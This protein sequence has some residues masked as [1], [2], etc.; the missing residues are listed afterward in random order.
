MSIN[1]GLLGLGNIGT[2][3]AEYL[4]DYGNREG[5]CLRAVAD[6]SPARL[7][8][9]ALPNVDIADDAYEIIRSPQLQIVVELIGGEHPAREYVMEAIEHGKAVVTANKFTISR[10]GRE[11]FEAARKQGVDVG[12]EASV[13]GGIPIIQS[14]REDLAA[15]TISLIT[16]IVNGTT[17]Y[18]LTRMS[19]GMEYGDA[20][21]VAQEKG[22]AER[23]PYLDVSGQD[24]R[25]KLA[26][27][28]SVA[29]NTWI[30][31]DSISCEGTA[32]ITPKD[33]DFAAEF[34]YAIKLLATAR[35]RGGRAELR[36][37]PTLVSVYHPLAKVVDEFNAI[38]LE[39]NLCGPQMY[40]GRGAGRP[41]TTSAVIADIMRIARDIARGV[42]DNLPS[43]DEE[44][45]LV[46]D[47]VSG[48]YFRLDLKHVAGSLA[49]V[50]EVLAKHGI[51]IK[52]SVQRN[53]F[54]REVDGDTVIPDIIT[55]EPVE[56][57]RV[58]RALEELEK[59]DR[60][61]GKPF[62]LRI[63][64]LSDTSVGRSGQS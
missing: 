27:L 1:V 2:G 5:L 46:E 13:G 59:C 7:K 57:S 43:L 6:V 50:A 42:H 39:G 52:D 58:R 40:L 63:E 38:Y 41:A 3:V 11:I 9:T 18:I 20:L 17:N 15:N 36:V 55:V 62:Y 12:F 26:I 34:G 10:Y 51:S 23:D 8:N 48:G 45:E 33:M 32:E 60:V 4:R 16:G 24:A 28:A 61:F 19:E 35:K 54:R 64:D 44:H 37:S 31:P 53:R 22:F 56:D 47:P 30:H 25:H 29:W 21:R 49:K 14:L